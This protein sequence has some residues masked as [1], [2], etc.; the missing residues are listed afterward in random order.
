MGCIYSY[1]GYIRWACAV[2]TPRDYITDF[3][4]KLPVIQNRRG[5]YAVE[6]GQSEVAAVAIRG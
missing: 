4:Q 1:R 6:P 3:R 5:P 2:F